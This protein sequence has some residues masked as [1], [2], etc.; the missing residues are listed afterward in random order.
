[1]T[2]KITR[3][4]LLSSLFTLCFALTAQNS[5][6]GGQLKFS[7]QALLDQHNIKDVQLSPDGKY[8][9]YTLFVDG[10]ASVMLT[11]VVQG[12][13]AKALIQPNEATVLFATWASDSK[14]V[15]VDSFD[16]NNSS[17]ELVLRIDISNGE[18]RNLLSALND[19][20]GSY[21]F[22]T[23]ENHFVAPILMYRDAGNADPLVRYQVNFANGTLTEVKK[24]NDML[25]FAFATCPTKKL[26]LQSSKADGLRLMVRNNDQWAAL[27]AIETEDRFAPNI[28]LSC[29]NSN[30]QIH[31]LGNTQRDFNSI[32]SFAYS[33]QEKPIVTQQ[34]GDITSVLI[35]RA[36]GAIDGYTSEFATA[37]FTP[38]GPGLDAMIAPHR[39]LF[40]DRFEVVSI[41]DSRRRAVIFGKT[42]RDAGA[43]Y[44]IGADTKAAIKLF[45][46]KPNLPPYALLPTTAH[47]SMT[48]DG[49][50]LTLYETRP[51][52]PCGAHGCPVVLAVHG[53]PRERD[54]LNYDGN[55]QWLAAQGYIVV[56][57]NY[58]GS[59]GLGRRFL[60]LGQRQWGAKMQDDV[61]DALQWIKA[62]PGGNT[63]K[64]AI[65]G[66]SYGGFSALSAAVGAPTAFSCAVSKSGGSNL[67]TF[68][69]KLTAKR[70][71][72][73]ADLS[74]NVGDASTEAGR[75]DLLARSPISKIDQL[76]RPI[77]IL[78][79]DA[80]DDSPVEEVQ[81]FD[82]QLGA[83]GK[84]GL[85]S[86]F[87]FAGEGHNFTNR[88]NQ[89]AQL[90]LTE[91]FL[92][93][94]FALQP[95]AAMPAAA[96]I[97]KLKM[98]T[99][100]DGYGI[101]GKAN[102]PLRQTGRAQ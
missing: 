91:R 27:S 64:I 66:A 38:L 97:K 81:E 59:K 71:N 70:P 52:K 16:P 46:S 8:V 57:V 102:E 5:W 31:F 68:I 51:T 74:A 48:R 89:D 12:S 72:L 4:R 53:G 25:P 63:N 40:T 80:D 77:L 30:E 41:A 84:S 79:G 93:Q 39:A 99:V 88:N 67:L 35:H 47:V 96:L 100:K 24:M 55:R 36:T 61:M 49:E 21:F 50:I 15:I 17:K 11:A 65:F 92:R 98:T 18:K 43:Y 3:K 45:G 75:R 69:E 29:S 37:S 76:T 44:L 58:R 9:L 32:A 2:K 86:I 87:V 85:A 56:N 42:P 94:C 33:A 10:K 23:H 22:A 26:A 54:T 1:M 62:R 28:P 34:L 60:N 90:M 20:Q 6:A 19:P 7:R 78:H 82:A 73:A 101:L 14:S 95:T 13:Q 83:I